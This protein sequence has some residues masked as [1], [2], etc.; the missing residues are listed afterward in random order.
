MFGGNIYG[1]GSRR[2][3]RCFRSAYDVAFKENFEGCRVDTRRV[4]RQ[5]NLA[6]T[7][8]RYLAFWPCVREVRSIHTT[9]YKSGRE[10]CPAP[11]IAI[12]PHIR[13]GFSYKNRCRK[14]ERKNAAE[15]V[16][17]RRINLSMVMEVAFVPWGDRQSGHLRV[18][19]WW[20][21]SSLRDVLPLTCYSH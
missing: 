21:Q 9:L 15:L 8:R 1:K 7:R 5:G 16:S 4:D 13:W 6:L 2:Y 17:S 14:H 10:C 3:G 19:R 12:A 18:P 11:C 20:L